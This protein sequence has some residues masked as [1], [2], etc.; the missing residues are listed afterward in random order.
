MAPLDLSE[1]AFRLIEGGNLP[2]VAAFLIGLIAAISPCPLATNI[3]AMSYIT[4]TITDRRYVIVSGSLY[5]L[6]RMFTYTVIGMLVIL[7][8]VSIPG[9]ARALQ[10]SGEIFLGPL[11]IIVGVL[12]LGIIRLPFL[13]GGGRL[14]SIGE[15]VAK[16]RWLGPFLLGVIFA[17]AFCPYTALLFFGI[18]MPISIESTGGITFP[19]V[20]AIGTGL[21]VLIFAVLLSFSIAK[22]ASWMNKITAAEKVLRKIVALIFIGVGIYFIVVWIQG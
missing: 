5:T 21:P 17:L 3:S 13:Q 20:F 12:M 7:A 9:L 4:R 15:R 2:I 8:G 6:G 19:A 11:L 10:D 1:F 18:L 22:V 14:A 16:R